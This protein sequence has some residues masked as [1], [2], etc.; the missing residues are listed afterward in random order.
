MNVGIAD[1]GSTLIML[2]FFKFLYE[3]QATWGDPAAE[4]SLCM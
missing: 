1:I 3:S 2:Y 4:Y